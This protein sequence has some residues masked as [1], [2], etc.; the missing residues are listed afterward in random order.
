M[1]ATRRPLLLFTEPG[2][3]VTVA[4]WHTDESEPMVAQTEWNAF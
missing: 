3:R 2:I 1:Y 4:A